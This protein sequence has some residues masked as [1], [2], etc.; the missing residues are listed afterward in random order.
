M[1]AVARRC[2][3]MEAMLEVMEVVRGQK[4]LEFV[5]HG[6]DLHGDSP[7]LGYGLERGSAV[8]TLHNPILQVREMTRSFSGGWRI[9][10]TTAM[11]GPV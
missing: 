11:V 1:P 4:N 5:A 2:E 9:T 8:W 7:P 10:S 3:A 6:M